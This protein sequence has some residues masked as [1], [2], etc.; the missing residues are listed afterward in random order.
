M[1]YFQELNKIDCSEHT[2][3]KGQFT[4]LSWAWAMQELGKVHPDAIINVKRFPLPSQPEISVPYMQTPIGFF[5]EV[6]VIIEGVARSQIH[7]VLDNRNKPLDKPNTFQINT[8]IQRAL[9]KA[10]SLH[11]L[12]LYIYAGEDLP[13]DA[14]KYTKEQK[15]A[16]DVAISGKEILG[17]LE[18]KASVSEDA[19]I[20]LFNSFE[21]GNKTNGKN[22]ARDLEREG[23]AAVE[24]YQQQLTDCANND[25]QPGVE[26][27]KE[28]MGRV[29]FANYVYP[30]LDKGVQE[31]LTQ[32]KKAA[33]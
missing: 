4:Y 6:E 13:E 14:P 5:V 9:V 3:Q 22:L 26:E 18:I 7:P 23:F 8:S 1:S 28:E 10:I 31:Y 19:Y 16:F 21:K 17:I 33:A 25:D 24:A 11:G 27:L 15:K 30:H 20:D 12:G 29:I 2:E 32:M